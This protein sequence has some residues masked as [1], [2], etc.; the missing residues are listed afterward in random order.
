MT[1]TW[2]DLIDFSLGVGALATVDYFIAKAIRWAEAK[3]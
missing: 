3:P 1:I 2:R